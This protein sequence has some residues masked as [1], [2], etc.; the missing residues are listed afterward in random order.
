MRRQGFILAAAVA[1][2]AGSATAAAPADL[3]AA[4][5]YT[6]GITGFVPVVCRASFDANLV[7][8]T[9][10][11]VELGELNEFCNSPTGYQVFVDSSPE[12]AGAT[13]KVDGHAVTLS[14]EGPTLLVSSAAPGMTAR[15]LALSGSGAGGSLSFRI[16]PL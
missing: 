15:D 3:S 13:L 12:L 7:P 11:E 14:A 10:S 9:G 4:N 2:S 5:S 1:L 8:V 16:V 6:I